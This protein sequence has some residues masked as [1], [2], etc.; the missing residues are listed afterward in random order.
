M[1]ST[2]S[3][4][5]SPELGPASEVDVPG[6]K[7]R[8]H[9]TGSGPP[10]VF[11]HGLLANPNLW[12][13]VIGRLSKDYRCVALELPLGAH[14]IPAPDADLTP[15]GLA[16]LIADA[17]ERLDLDD[18][19]LVGNDTGGALCQLVVTQRRDRI[20]RLVLTSCDAFENFPPP[21]FKWVLMP[22][23]L[24]GPGVPL[25]FAPLR[26]RP[27]R[28]LPIAFGWLTKRP[29]DSEQAEDSYVYPALTDSAIRRDLRRVLKGVD[30]KHTLDAAEKLHRFDRP[31]LI[32]WSA[33][34]RVFP[35]AHGER[36]A[37]LFPNARLEWVE[38][39]YS[40]SPE[41]NPERLAELVG[42]FAREPRR[43]KAGAS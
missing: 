1:A 15:P 36:L 28:R 26:L 5:R 37:A 34:D 4:W 29:I 38:D 13:K 2:K 33:D 42:A 22:G 24:P 19:T 30:P 18:V 25:L 8:Y 6:A 21:L 20:E 35:P 17:I 41:D 3:S 12:R 39:S 7:L 9:E 14:A 11:V 40:F 16:N 31:T 32:A 43:E 10:L 23:Q 27:L